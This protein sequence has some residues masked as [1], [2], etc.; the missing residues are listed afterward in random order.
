MRWSSQQSIFLTKLFILLFGAGYLAVVLTCPLLMDV[1]VRFSFFAAGK[2]KWLFSGTVYLCAIPVG[3]LLWNLWR[4][5]FDIG[6]EQIFT[7]ENIRRLRTISWMCIL[8]ALICTFSMTYYVFWGII[9]ACLLF[10]GLLIRVIKNTFQ[11]AR[12]LKE[13]V[14]FTI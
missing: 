11:Q 1:F 14:D 6:L 13:E 8:T 7:T 9:S 2:N 4:L 12:E 10:M 5:I 3:I